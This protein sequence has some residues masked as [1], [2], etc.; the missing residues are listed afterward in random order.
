[1]LR[2]ILCSSM[3]KEILK[4]ECAKQSY[5]NISNGALRVDALLD[6]KRICIGE[7]LNDNR[8]YSRKR[9]PDEIIRE[10][11]HFL[12]S[13]DN[14]KTFSWGVISKVLSNEETIVLPMLQRTTTRTKLW[15]MYYESISANED[16]LSKR[17][18]FMSRSTFFLVCNAVTC[19]EERIIGSVDYVQ[20]LLLTEPIEALQ[21]IVDKYFSGDRHK[22][23]TSYLLSVTQFLKYTYTHHMSQ[24]DD[25]CTHG[26]Y[27]ALGRADSHYD[28][29]NEVKKRVTCVACR[30]P[31]YVC[32]LVQNEVIKADGC[33]EEMSSDAIVACKDACN[34]FNLFMAHRMRCKNQQLALEN[35]ATIMK[36]RVVYSKGECTIAHMVIDFKMK[37]EPMSTR[38]TTLDHYGKRGIGWHGIHL[39]YYTLHEVTDEDGTTKLEPI[40]QSLYIDQIL[41]DGNKQ[42]SACVLSLIDSA[43]TMIQYNIPEIKEV[44][45]QSDNANSYQNMF[46]IAGLA[47]LNASRK[48]GSVRISKYTHTETQDGK[49]VLDAHF[50]TCMR[51]L[52]IF[53]KTWKANRVTRINTANGLGFAL[54]WKGGLHNVMV[55]VV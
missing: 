19:S 32:D 15:E 46:L 51:F 26:F 29:D 4:E 12:L 24:N 41:D 13:V 6:Y 1:M 53:M 21:E 40:K 30:F 31:S 35:L 36:T 38:E 47:L 39:V 8:M 52:Y 16:T 37:F 14:V 34:K 5:T 43:L 3:K 50:A 42:D 45:L 27:Y 25:C 9:V 28:A 17:K 44:I 18:L 48:K 54:A 49:T 22:L 7:L 33:N 55:Q 20:S 10:V 11:V 2:A 23:I